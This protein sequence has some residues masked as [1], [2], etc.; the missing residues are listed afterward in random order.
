MVKVMSAAAVIFA[1]TAGVLWAMFLRPVL[2]QHGTAEIRAKTYKPAGTYWQ[3]QVGISRGFR[4]P[5]PIPVA[6]SYV[7]ELYCSEINSAGFFSI[8][9]AEEAKYQVGQH[10]A[11]EYQRRGLPLVGYR[12]TVL[13]VRPQ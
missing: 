1:A 6:E 4:T 9:T 12:T 2:I 10:V 11:I 8:A 7:L 5:T 3:Q 13:S